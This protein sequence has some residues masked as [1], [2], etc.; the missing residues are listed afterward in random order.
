MFNPVIIHSDK[1]F[2]FIS[3]KYS[4]EIKINFSNLKIY[5]PI[6][7]ENSGAKKQMF[8]QPARLRN[9]TYWSL[10]SINLEIQFIVQFGENLNEKK[11]NS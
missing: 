9:F 5:S 8:P 6:M 7:Y 3:E 4:L 2:D 1:D 10:M 11:N